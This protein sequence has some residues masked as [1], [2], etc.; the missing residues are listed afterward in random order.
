MA[1]EIRSFGG[2][3]IAVGVDVCET[4]QVQNMISET[5]RAFGAL[6]ILVN[7][8]AAGRRLDGA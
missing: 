6:H 4:D 3:A 2:K 5:V 7:N 8:A 1:S